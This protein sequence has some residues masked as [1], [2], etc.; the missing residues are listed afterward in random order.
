[1]S[2]LLPEI[3]KLLA[4]ADTLNAD[5]QAWAADAYEVLKRVCETL[6]FYEGLTVL[7]RDGVT[8]IDGGETAQKLHELWEKGQEVERLER[9]IAKYKLVAVEQEVRVMDLVE[10]LQGAEAML[11]LLRHRCERTIPWGTVAVPQL[12][13]VEEAITKARRALAGPPAEEKPHHALCP[14]ETR[15][16]QRCGSDVTDPIHRGPRASEGKNGRG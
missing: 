3:R 9:D 7:R 6:E 4:E 8:S 13:T 10:A 11:S 16:C 12:R 14:G 15:I 5:P 2:D 1:M